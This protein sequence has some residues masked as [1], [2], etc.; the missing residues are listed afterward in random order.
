MKYNKRMDVPGKITPKW[1]NDNPEYIFVFGDNCLRLGKKGQAICRG[2]PNAYGFITKKFPSN[3]KDAFYKP[4]AYEEIFKREIGKLKKKIRENVNKT[5]IIPKLGS[6]LAN[7]Y[8]IY[9]KVIK[10]KIKEEL[11][12]F[13]NIVFI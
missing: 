6:G 7:K 9:E 3:D 10:D 5:F 4:S 11:A 13:N 2:C 1:L 12:E 8:N